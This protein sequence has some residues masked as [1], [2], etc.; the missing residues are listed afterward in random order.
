MQEWADS[1]NVLFQKNLILSHQHHSRFW[2]NVTV[3]QN[4][5]QLKVLPASAITVVHKVTAVMLMV[6]EN[7]PV[8]CL[9]FW[10]SKAFEV[11]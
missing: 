7:V 4:V 2:K 9:L 6:V 5:A 1:T 10:H 8:K 11:I 3:G